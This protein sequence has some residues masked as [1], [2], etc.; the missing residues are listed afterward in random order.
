MK[1]RVLCVGGP[2]ALHQ[3]LESA[4]VAQNMHF[5]ASADPIAVIEELQSPHEE[6]VDILIWAVSEP[7]DAR[8]G[9]ISLEGFTGYLDRAV[10][11]A[12]RA[13]Q[14][15]IGGMERRRFGRFLALSNLSTHLGDDDILAA[16]AGGALEGLVKSVAREGARKGVTANALVLGMLSDWEAPTAAISRP[17][18]EHYFPFREAFGV[19]D[20]AKA[21]VEL[22]SSERLN[23]QVI[24]FDG[25]TL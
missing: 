5:R 25:G 18:Y 11:S 13:I 8:L 17:F 22:A 14:L 3:H 1:R 24:R 7:S 4:F 16:L 10:H 20:L 9:A 21:V 23:G 2:A 6:G 12:F 19:A 15:C